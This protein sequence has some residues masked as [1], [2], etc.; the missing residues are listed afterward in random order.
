MRLPGAV[1]FFIKDRLQG[2][3]GNRFLWHLRKKSSCLFLTFDDGPDPDN[4]PI[5]LDALAANGVRAVFSAAEG[6]S[7]RLPAHVDAARSDPGRGRHG[8]AARSRRGRGTRS[9][10]QRNRGGLAAR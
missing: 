3:S 10:R 1:K 6:S 2:I 5:I 9:D 4:T 7:A 8:V